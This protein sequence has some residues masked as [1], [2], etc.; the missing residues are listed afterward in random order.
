MAVNSMV[1]VFNEQASEI[2]PAEYGFNPQAYLF[3]FV[4]VHVN[5]FYG[6]KFFADNEAAKTGGKTAGKPI[7]GYL[8]LIN[9]NLVRI[10]FSLI[11]L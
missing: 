7:A 10:N 11:K 5:R 8:S 1:L 4:F 3:H 2:L 9:A 6:S